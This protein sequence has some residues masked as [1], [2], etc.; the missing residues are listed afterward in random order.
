MEVIGETFALV[1]L[2]AAPSRCAVSWHSS[3]RR[4]LGY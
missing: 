2:R 1:L 3:L 4:P